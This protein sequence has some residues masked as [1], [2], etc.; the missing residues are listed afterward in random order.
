MLRLTSCGSRCSLCVYI[1]A[2]RFP[3]TFVFCTFSCASPENFLTGRADRLRKCQPSCPNIVDKE[4]TPLALEPPLPPFP[5][6]SL[7]SCVSQC[8]ALQSGVMSMFVLDRQ[9]CGP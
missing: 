5:S 6:S 4:H 2:P 1:W 8:R 3:S 9:I 7:L